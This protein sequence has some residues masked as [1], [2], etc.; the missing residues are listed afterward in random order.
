MN[1]RPDQQKVAKYRGGMMA[2]PAIPGAGKTFTLVVLATQLIKEE[3]HK[4]GKI[5]IV[6]YMNSAV[7][8][9]KRRIDKM[10]EKEGLQ[11][12]KGYEVMTLHALAMK[13]IKEKPE[14]VLVSNEFDILDDLSK[15][16]ILHKLVNQWISAN[17]ERFYS[18]IDFKEGESSWQRNNKINTWLKKFTRVVSEMIPYLKFKNV[19]AYHL[20]WH[21]KNNKEDLLSCVAE[22]Y[23]AYDMELKRKG[24]LDFEDIICYAIEL[25]KIDEVLREKMQNKYTYIFEDEAQD[26]SNLQEEMLFLLAKKHQN[27]VRVGDSNQS[28]M[29]SFTVSDPKLFKQY[30]IRDDVQKNKIA[31]SSRNTKDIINLANFL[32]EWSQELHPMVECKTSLENQIIKTVEDDD[33]FP[34]PVTDSYR[35]GT[36]VYESKEEEVKQ[37]SKWAAR[38]ASEN[39]E[40]TIAILMPSNY[41]MQDYKGELTL[42]GAKVREITSFPAERGQAAAAISSLLNFL[43]MPYD[44]QLFFQ[45]LKTAFIPEL[46]DEMKYAAF[47]EFI[48]KCEIENLFY[49][50]SGQLKEKDIPQDVLEEI[51]F[52]QLSDILSTIKMI[53]EA[54][55]VELGALVIF[56]AE[57]LKFDDEKMAISQKIASDIRYMLMLNPDWGMKEVAMEL[58][59]I[60]NSLNY[61][62][63]IVYERKGF[64]PVKG[65][66]NLLTYHKSKGLEFDTVYLTGMTSSDFP[67]TLNDRFLSDYWCL[68]PYYRNPVSLM[69]VQVDQLKGGKEIEDPGKNAKIEVMGERL[70]LLY[71]GITRAK[72][73]L[74]LSAYKEFTN[75]ET[76][77]KSKTAPTLYLEEIAKFAKE[78]RKEYAKQA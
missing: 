9:F 12:N 31:A 14:G 46:E 21:T 28:I 77:K 29:S 35:I 37:I 22:I 63:N 36:G 62:A 10:L 13:I 30:C 44:Y 23:S 66:I 51:A 27:L 49:P 53:L 58:G 43:A 52:E 18:F 34:N 20:L 45:A 57:L 2:V 11:K 48:T 72:E 4:P 8:N 39:P 73:N 24:L 64:E 42:L 26:S 78:S 6:T 75:K 40:K 15:D 32:V 47:R 61:F 76:G 71:V 55:K 16:R 74:F 1:L 60:K 67:A 7:S 38:Y 54:K 59:E 65:E 50:I 17:N 41:A 68:K 25:L 56:I 3:L 5:L 69:K 70:R 19:T 33:P